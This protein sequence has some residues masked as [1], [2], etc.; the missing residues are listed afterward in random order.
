MILRMTPCRAGRKKPSRHCIGHVPRADEVILDDSG[1]AFGG[2]VLGR[3]G[4]LAT[5]II[6]EE[7]EACVVGLNL[8]GEGV[9]LF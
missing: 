8:V 3:G 9:D 5:G 4:V 7:V 2:D 6:D 1:E